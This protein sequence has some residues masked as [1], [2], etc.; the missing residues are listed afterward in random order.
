MES[1]NEVAGTTTYQIQRTY[2][3]PDATVRA[4]VQG[5]NE[6]IVNAGIGAIHLSYKQ[7]H[8]LAR[9]LGDAMLAHDLMYGTGDL[10]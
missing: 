10:S 1:T 5:D 2:L 7:A 4:N 8:R 3:A 9:Q 6:I